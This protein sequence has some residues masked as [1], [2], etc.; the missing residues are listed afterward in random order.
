LAALFGHKREES[1][2][3]VCMHGCFGAEPLSQAVVADKT[4]IGSASTRSPGRGD[5]DGIPTE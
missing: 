2:I 3:F 5:F 1:E 4:A